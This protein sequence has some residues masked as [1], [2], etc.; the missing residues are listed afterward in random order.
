M[1]IYIC[2]VCLSVGRSVG[3][4][5]CRSV[6][7]LSHAVV[8]SRA[9]ITTRYTLDLFMSVS[10]SRVLR[11]HCDPSEMDADFG[12]ILG[13]FREDF[14]DRCRL[15]PVRPAEDMRVSLLCHPSQ[16]SMFLAVPTAHGTLKLRNHLAHFHL[17]S[18]LVESATH[19]RVA[20]CLILFC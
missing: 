9:A 16:C 17:V 7:L 3:L 1:I 14:G 18:T 10:G 4:S 19:V 8:G 12:W 5:V 20:T 2:T 13:V 11:R 15:H 6:C